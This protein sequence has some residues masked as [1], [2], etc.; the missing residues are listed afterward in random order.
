MK[1]VFE[2]STRQEL[3]NRINSLHEL[4]NRQW[5]K[6]NISQML[7]HCTLHEEMMLGKIKI[8]RVLPGLLFGRMFLKRV[9]KDDKPFGKNSPTSSLLKTPDEKGDIEQQKKEWINRIEK[10]PDY[11]N[12]SFVHP[13]FGPMTRDQIGFYAYKHADHHLRQFDA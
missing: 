2:A 4:S 10:Y 6:M 5:G 3:T 8:K 9:L 7:R 13:F 12:P 11:T 1:S